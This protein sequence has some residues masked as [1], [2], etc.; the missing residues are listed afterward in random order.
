MSDEI[1]YSGDKFTIGKDL[2]IAFS[3]TDHSGDI[4]Y[5]VRGEVNGH[6]L[7][8]AAD[9][10]YPNADADHNGWASLV[11]GNEFADKVLRTMGNQKTASM[12]TDFI[13]YSGGKWTEGGQLHQIEYAKGLVI[14]LSIADVDTTKPK[15][16]VALSSEGKAGYVVNFSRVRVKTTATPIAGATISTIHVQSDGGIE[17][18][19]ADIKLPVTTAGKHTITITVT[20]S[21]GF[22][23]T[24]TQTYTA[25]AVKDPTISSLTVTRTDAE[26]NAS[27]AGTCAKVAWTVAIDQTVTNTASI[28]ITA[29]G[30]VMTTQTALTGSF[31]TGAIFPVSETGSLVFTVRDSYSSVSVTRDVPAPFKLITGDTRSIAFGKTSRYNGMME[32]ALPLSVQKNTWFA[33]GVSAQDIGCTSLKVGGK[34]LIDW[35]HPVG[36]VLYLRGGLDPNTIYSGTTWKLKYF[37]L[38]TVKNI[39][40]VM[41]LSDGIVKD[42]QPI[43]LWP[44]TNTND[45]GK[46]GIQAFDLG[47]NGDTPIEIKM[48]LRTA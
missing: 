5:F 12:Q 8:M 45:N 18:Y 7:T 39:R 43:T 36:S 19:G 14:S 6:Y 29:G 25:V 37:S 24:V 15:A 26:G 21:R 48:W 32:I 33:G 41:T 11:P 30:K 9:W 47:A 13:K 27:D 10:N 4:M 31:I 46:W 17:A 22:A 23:R 28:E 35:I 2:G 40:D 16:S 44:M 42:G 20:D 38:A 3:S 1:Y 34:T